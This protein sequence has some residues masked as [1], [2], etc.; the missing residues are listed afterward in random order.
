METGLKKVGTGKLV[1]DKPEHSWD[2]EVY[3]NETIT[4]ASGDPKEKNT[5]KNNVTDKDGNVS[6]NS[7]KEGTTITA[8]WLNIG[9]SNRMT[10]PNVMTGETVYIYNY[11][12]TDEYFW[13]DYETEPGLRK[14]ES[15]LYFFSNKKGIMKDGWI[16]KGY[17]M[18]IDTINKAVRLFTDAGNGELTTYKMEILTK[19][20]IL[21]IEDGKGNKIKLSSASDTW[22]IESNNILNIKTTSEV[23]IKTT[24]CTVNATNCTI[25][26]SEFIVKSGVTKIN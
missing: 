9:G 22:D 5:V 6:S 20:G 12:G 14:E 26:A 19:E 23:N 3:L 1:K 2:I 16:A 17:Y 25:N 18:L 7:I 4:D 24:N 8:R 13:S 21:L 15:V 11:G 10:P